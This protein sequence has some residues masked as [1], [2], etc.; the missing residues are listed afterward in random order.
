MVQNNR[1]TNADA[2]LSFK[3]LLDEGVITQAE[4][5]AK[6]RE[7]LAGPAMPG[8]SASAGSTKPLAGN[9]LKIVA[10]ALSAIA[11]LWGL[12]SLFASFAGYMK[13]GSD[14]GYYLSMNFTAVLLLPLASIA[15]SICAL[16]SC[17][18]KQKSTATV[19][20]AIGLA[21]AAITFLIWIVNYMNVSVTYSI[22]VPL[23][24]VTIIYRLCLIAAPAVS[25]A[26]L[27]R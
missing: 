10:L 2:L 24:P 14:F 4:Y 8:G 16:A 26:A 15:G 21:I 3:K 20:A 13:M 23:S 5:D 22:S 7:L 1:T 12:W 6:K 18:M 17:L 9:P 27:R 11:L 19:L 25:L